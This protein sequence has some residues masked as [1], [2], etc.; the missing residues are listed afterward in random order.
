MRSL[1]LRLCFLATAVALLP[2]PPVL[3][4]RIVSLHSS[5]SGE[6]IAA[7]AKRLGLTPGGEQVQPSSASD[8]DSFE[9]AAE[10]AGFSHLPPN[11]VVF[12]KSL[13][14]KYD[15]EAEAEAAE[16][17]I[18]AVSKFK[19]FGVDQSDRAKYPAVNKVS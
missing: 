14:E 10:V 2:T 12:D 4:R 6:S 5:P 3:P 7:R 19:A 8:K 16:A 18:E 1:L 17:V 9:A 15:F 13:Y 11:A